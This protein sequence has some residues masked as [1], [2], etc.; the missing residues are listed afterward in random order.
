MFMLS[1]ILMPDGSRTKMLFDVETTLPLFYPL[2]YSIDHLNNR[3]AS[4]QEASLQAIKYFYEYWLVK[5]GK[6]FCYSFFDSNHSPSIAINELDSFFQYLVDGYSYTP[7]LIKFNPIPST[8]IY[9]HA[10]R[11]RAVAR[12]IKYLIGKYVNAHYY[13]DEPKE[14]IRYSDRLLRSLKIKTEGYSSLLI[15][16]KIDASNVY[17]GYKSLTIEM[18]AAIYKII[19][20]SSYKRKNELNPFS[21]N[22]VQLRNYLIVRILLNYGLRVGELMLLEL[23]SIKTNM[24]GDKYSLIITNTSDGNHD[25]RARL[26]SLKTDNAHRVIDIEQSDYEFLQLYIDKIRPKVKHRFIFAT[27]KKPFSPLS[28]NAIY[29]LFNKIDEIFTKNHPTFKNPKYSD[30]IDNLTPHVARH[31]WAYITLEK[32][33]QKK[34][35]EILKLSSRSGIDFS[36]NGIMEDSKSEL[37]ELAGWS[38]GSHMPTH[39]AKRFMRDRANES[40]IERIKLE[41]A[42]STENTGDF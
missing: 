34:Y 41:T 18:V 4:S 33:Y 38:Y 12:F 10:E 35:E 39:Y 40:N 21:T 37:R 28:Y 1:F 32:I 8:S 42:I 27:L 19:T 30:S 16:R 29:C 14:I 13:D 5:Y 23:E 3:S 6:T 7:K 26:P 36:N 11:V 17:Q 9:T 24:R 22:S 25:P 2:R 20:P 31:T 15:R